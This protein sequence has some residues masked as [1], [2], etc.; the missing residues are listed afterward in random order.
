MTSF[1]K[2]SKFSKK[3]C[4]KSVFPK[5]SL[6]FIRF[7]KR[8]DNLLPGFT[9]FYRVVPGC[10][11]FSL[12]WMGLAGSFTGFCLSFTVSFQGLLGFAVFFRATLVGTGNYWVWL[13][14]KEL[15]WHLIGI[16][17]FYWVLMGFIELNWPLLGITGFLLGFIELENWNLVGTT[18]F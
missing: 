5:V 7:L 14:F 18:R 1:L 15:Y 3:N 12:A 9:G 16:N 17:G 8:R 6:S 13:S 4:F 2:T 10:D 11:G